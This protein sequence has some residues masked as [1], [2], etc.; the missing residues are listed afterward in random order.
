MRDG[1]RRCIYCGHDLFVCEL[2]RS[3]WY[4]TLDHVLPRSLRGADARENLVLACRRCNNEKGDRNVVLF[5]RKL[6]HRIATLEVKLHNSSAQVARLIGERDAA[7]ATAI[8]AG[9]PPETFRRVVA[10]ESVPLPPALPPFGPDA[11]PHDGMILVDGEPVYGSSGNV[12]SAQRRNAP[13]EVMVKANGQPVPARSVSD[14]SVRP[15]RRNV[16]YGGPPELA[17]GG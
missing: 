17:H 6:R 13:A 5:L 12:P 2:D 10:V 4:V 9:V 3:P 1:G 8:A 7:M 14:P 15:S 11:G 16:S